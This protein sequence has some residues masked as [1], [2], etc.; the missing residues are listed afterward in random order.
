[1]GVYGFRLAK[2]AFGNWFEAACWRKKFWT[3]QFSSASRNSRRHENAGRTTAGEG[4]QRQRRGERGQ[5]LTYYSA[6]TKNHSSVGESWN[7]WIPLSLSRI[8]ALL[9]CGPWFLSF[10][11][12]TSWC[13]C[14]TR[15]IKQ[16]W[17]TFLLDFC[18][19]GSSNSLHLIT[20]LVSGYQL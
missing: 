2:Q 14:S 19:R 1:M 8:L 5:S 11:T 4:V 20:F 9:C 18:R 3:D 12:W 17:T 15:K 16:N 13:L 6:S 7:V 10:F